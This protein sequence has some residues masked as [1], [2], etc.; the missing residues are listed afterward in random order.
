MAASRRKTTRGPGALTVSDDHPRL[1]GI[2]VAVTNAAGVPVRTPGLAAW[3][4]EVAPARARGDVSLVFVDNR[5]MRVLNRTFRR[6]DAP[7]DVLSFPVDASHRP[8]DGV[9]GEI[10]IAVGVATRQAAEQGHPLGTEIRVLALHGLL[11]LLGY[12]HETDDGQMAR[13]EA[14]LRRKGGLVSG[15]IARVQGDRR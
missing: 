11:H 10:V 15:L 4:A 6:V 5:R 8:V 3:L 2:T 12:D 7:T 13:V 1:R 14:R 9:L